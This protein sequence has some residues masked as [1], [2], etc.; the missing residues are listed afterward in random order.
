MNRIVRQALA[1]GAGFAT[2]VVLSLAAD[3]A[4]DASS[5]S[6]LTDMNNPGLAV[7]TLYRALFTVAGGAITTLLARGYGY[8]PAVILAGIGVV[9]G[10]A[11]VAAWFAVPDLGPLWYPVAVLV[12][13]PPCALAGAWLVLR[14]G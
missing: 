10:L 4:L 8:R 5:L 9:G 6:P 11:G 3:Q 13:G 12:T 7:A 2:V 1:I 14:R